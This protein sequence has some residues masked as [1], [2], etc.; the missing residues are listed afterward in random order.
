[1]YEETAL[2]RKPRFAS[3]PWKAALLLM[4]CIDRRNTVYGSDGDR[5]SGKSRTS[6]WESLISGSGRIGT[7]NCTVRLPGRVNKHV[8]PSCRKYFSSPGS[9]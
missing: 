7:V 3:Q 9:I 5:T 8:W 1:M 2:S 4:G 6:Y